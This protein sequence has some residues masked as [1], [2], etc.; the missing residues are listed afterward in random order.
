MNLN[1]AVEQIIAQN[2]M[3]FVFRANEVER[4]CTTEL[5]A[6]V[7]RCKEFSLKV[8]KENGRVTEFSIRKC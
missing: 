8:L 6:E 5:I 7:Y 4:T 2:E 1:V 3:F